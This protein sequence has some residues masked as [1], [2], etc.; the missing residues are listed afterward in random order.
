MFFQTYGTAV[1]IVLAAVLV[2]HAICRGG[3]R[4]QRWFATP[5][6]GLAALIILDG[7]A[8][9]LSG[10]QGKVVV[11][12]FW[13]TWCP[14]CRQEVPQLTRLQK[15]NQERGL[16]VVGLHI[17][18]RGRSTPEASS[19]IGTRPGAMGFPAPKAPSFPAPSGWNKRSPRP[20]EL[21][22]LSAGKTL[23]PFCTLIF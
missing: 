14:P 8:I 13:A 9:K 6:V 18:D 17:D 21:P 12:D 11:M 19:C 1:V 3:G 10:Y 23:R 16:E 2:G 20:D 5:A 15:E 4:D 7:A 22:K